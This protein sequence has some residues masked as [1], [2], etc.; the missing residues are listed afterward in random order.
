M[1][2]PIIVAYGVGRD[3]TALL[4]E[5]HRRGIRPDAILFANIGSEKRETYQFIPVFAEW[6]R[7]HDFPALTT[8]CYR[9]KSAPYRT[10]EGNMILNATLPGATFGKSSCTMKFKVE[11]Q[12]AWTKTWAPA[13][14]AWAAGRK[15]V[16][17]IGFECGEEYRLRRADAKA[18]C[19][20][21]SD[22]ARYEYQYPL[23]DWNL[24]LGRCV[25][26]IKSTGLPVPPKSACYFCPNQQPAEVEE[27][28]EEDRARIIL[29][30]LTA[31]PY[32]VKIHGLW[33]RP[34]KA[35]GRPGSITEYILQ[36]GLPF[37]PLN[38]IARKIVLNPNCK[39]AGA[40]NTFDPPH[41]RV[42]LRSLLTAAGHPAPEIVAENDG[43]PG[44]YLESAREAPATAEHAV[45]ENLAACA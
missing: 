32:N 45:H 4:I 41:N 37:V 7:R 9:P 12:E 29:M 23:I 19:G 40:G 13:K 43:T 34:R 2:Q 21:F 18:H 31:E 16:R 15:V 27:L 26:I 6:L 35:D 28:S 24:D 14:A 42:S 38:S 11:P 22:S 8:V 1:R 33:R 30:E 20:R 3:S 39:K 25:D 5:M 17:M 36:Q 44:I 10:L